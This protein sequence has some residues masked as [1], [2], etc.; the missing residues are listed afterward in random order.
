VTSK[1]SLLL[2]TCITGVS[3]AAALLTEYGILDPTI[4]KKGSKRRYYVE[5]RG[6]ATPAG[7][8]YGAHSLRICAHTVLV[9]LGI[10]LEARL[11]RFGWGPHSESMCYTRS[12][13]SYK[14]V[15]EY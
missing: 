10:P 6:V 4:D 2:P 5:Y 7:C 14:L 3:R 12:N 8:H 13:P 9:L 15:F 11:A 1:I